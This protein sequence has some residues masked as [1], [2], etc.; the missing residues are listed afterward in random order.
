MPE[1]SSR[2]QII[3]ALIGTLGVVL[4]AWI[5]TRS[6][7]SEQVPAPAPTPTPCNLP[8]DQRWERIAPTEIVSAQG[9]QYPGRQAYMY[10]GEGVKLVAADNNQAPQRSTL[11]LLEDCKPL[12]PAH[13]L[14]ADIWAQGKGLY[15]HWGDPPDA[16]LYFSSR[17]GSDPRTNRREYIVTVPLK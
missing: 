9:P 11:I 16:V 12:G 6:K 17:D 13:S 8:K 1:T 2:T 3:V 10:T 15:S 7:I 14:H 4:A 5:A